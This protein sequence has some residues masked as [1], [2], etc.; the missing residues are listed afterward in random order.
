MIF[1]AGNN[2]PWK[3]DILVGRLVIQIVTPGGPVRSWSYKSI[4]YL[5]ISVFVIF[6]ILVLHYGRVCS[7]LDTYYYNHNLIMV[8]GN[9]FI[10][11]S[12]WGEGEGSGEKWSKFRRKWK[13]TGGRRGMGST[14]IGC[15]VL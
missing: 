14:E 9:S 7:S 3:G 10:T 4:L 6:F 8:R 1:K 15:R 5:L 12:R 13:V 2:K 11:S